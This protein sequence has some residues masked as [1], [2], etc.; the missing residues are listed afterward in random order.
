MKNLIQHLILAIVYVFPLSVGAEDCWMVGCPNNLGYVRIQQDN[1]GKYLPFNSQVLPAMG[2][3]Q[4][5]CAFAYLRSYA[6]A[7]PLGKEN[8]PGSPIGA[9]TR[10]KVLDH[11]R[12]DNGIDLLAVRVLEDDSKCPTSCGQCAGQTY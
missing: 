7:G 8:R 2:S 11:I 6:T 5:L 9:G 3:E 4:I 10:V 1:A 12:T